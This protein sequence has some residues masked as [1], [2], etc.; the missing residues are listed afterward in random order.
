MVAVAWVMSLGALGLEFMPVII[1]LVRRPG[2]N[3]ALQAGVTV[4]G[5]THACW[6]GCWRFTVIIRNGH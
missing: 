2:R 1:R 4:R 6:A 5:P 3:M